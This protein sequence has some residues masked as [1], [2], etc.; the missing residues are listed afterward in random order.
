MNLM[1]MTIP[2]VCSVVNNDEEYRENDHR[3]E[4]GHALS[5][6]SIL[7]LFFPV[8]SIDSDRRTRRSIDDSF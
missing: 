5:S 6:W 2:N 1:Y 7:F 3:K 4:G 8:D